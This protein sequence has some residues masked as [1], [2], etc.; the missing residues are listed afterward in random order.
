MNSLTEFTIYAK[1]IVLLIGA[2]FVFFFAYE[3]INKPE[4]V[5]H[6]LQKVDSA[7]F[8]NFEDQL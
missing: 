3:I 6:W 1:N 5:G 7:R 2:V 4:E 8:D